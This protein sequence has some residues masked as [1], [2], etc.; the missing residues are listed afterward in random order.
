MYLFIHYFPI[1]DLEG[2]EVNALVE[3]ED[4]IA[5]GGVVGETE[6]LLRRA[7]G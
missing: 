6:V 3:G 2:V 4:G 7:R 1:Q 5:D